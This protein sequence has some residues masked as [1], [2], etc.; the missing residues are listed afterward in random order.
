MID[1][2]RRLLRSQRREGA[3]TWR[4]GEGMNG[5]PLGGNVSAGSTKTKGKGFQVKGTACA[6]ALRHDR[7]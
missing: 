2:C 7:V 5:R 1:E 4:I 3:A 6:K